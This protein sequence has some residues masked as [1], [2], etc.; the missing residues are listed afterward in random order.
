MKILYEKTKLLNIVMV[1][2]ISASLLA[3]CRT[4]TENQTITS[5]TETVDTAASESA[6]ETN[7]ASEQ[8]DGIVKITA[9]LVQGT[10]NDGIYTY[11]GVPYAEATERFLP[12][13]EVKPWDGVRKA[14]AYGPMSPQG[15]ILGMPVNNNETGYTPEDVQKDEEGLQT[16]RTLGRNM[17]FLIKCISL[18]KEKFGLPE[19]EQR[20]ATNFIK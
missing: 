20:I 2:V 18:G 17:A 19:K 6:T 13:S 1:I 5:N 4:S 12:A 8:A 9:G 14:D 16:M 10:Y 7:S 3:G 15:A 11:L